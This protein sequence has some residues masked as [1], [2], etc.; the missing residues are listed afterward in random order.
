MIDESVSGTYR[1]VWVRT[2]VYT[3]RRPGDLRARSATRWPT[4]WPGSPGS[5]AGL[6]LALILAPWWINYLTRMLAWVNLLAGRRLRNNAPSAI[7]GVAPVAGCRATS[8][9]V[10]IALVYGYLP[11]FIMPLF[12]SLDR[13]DQ[14]LLE[15]SRDLGAGTLRTFLHVTLPLSK[16][17]L[18]TA[19]RD[20]RAADDR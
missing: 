3:A 15:A 8:F 20:H 12:A 17:G 18:V 13:I 7:F 16:L 5:G 9:T 14:R 19:H 4:T 6:L 2:V 1:P 10:V 11:F